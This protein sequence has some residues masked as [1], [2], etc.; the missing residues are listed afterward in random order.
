MEH[1][2]YKRSPEHLILSESKEVLKTNKYKTYDNG[3]CQRDP[4]TNSRVPKGQRQN[5][6]IK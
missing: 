5:K 1:E 2:I 6:K 4:E 3:V